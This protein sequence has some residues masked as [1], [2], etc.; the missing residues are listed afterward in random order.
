MS[1]DQE[2]R[3]WGRLDTTDIQISTIPMYI[4]LHYDK[5]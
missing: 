3:F 4:L 2:G 5:I 1:D